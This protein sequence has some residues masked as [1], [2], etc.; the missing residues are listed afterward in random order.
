MNI[1]KTI[2]IGLAVIA[3]GGLATLGQTQQPD[4]VTVPL[5]NPAMA[6]TTGSRIPPAPDKA[7]AEKE[8]KA[9]T[10]GMIT[11]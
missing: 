10:E 9:K 1:K 7:Q 11:P 8:T 2:W 5:T 6:A 3:L 4:K